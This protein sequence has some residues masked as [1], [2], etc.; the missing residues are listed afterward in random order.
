MTALHALITLLAC[1][2]FAENAA[3]GDWVGALAVCFVAASTV[4]VL[5]E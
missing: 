2:T 4:V 3:Q 5:P 1:A